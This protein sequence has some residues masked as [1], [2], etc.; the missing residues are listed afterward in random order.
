MRM[1]GDRMLDA[2][3]Y[4]GG[5]LCLVLMWGAIYKAVNQPKP[6]ST[7]EVVETWD[8]CDIIKYREQLFLKCR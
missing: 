7:I 8:D 1:R 6:P 3:V 4:I 5:V 2:F